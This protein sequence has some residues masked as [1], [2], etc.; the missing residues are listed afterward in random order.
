MHKISTFLIFLIVSFNLLDVY[1]VS[2]QQ[3]SASTGELEIG[4]GLKVELSCTSLVSSSVV[5]SIKPGETTTYRVNLHSNNWVISVYLPAPV[6]QWYSQE[7]GFTSS[8]PITITPGL[9]V[10][11]DVEPTT[12]LEVYGPATLDSTEINWNG[13]SSSRDIPLRIDSN[14]AENSL[15]RIKVAHSMKIRIGVNVGLAMFSYNVAS[16]DLTELELKPELNDYVEVK[17]A[18]GQF[19]GLFASMFQGPFVLILPVFILML[20]VSIGIYKGKKNADAIAKKAKK[21]TVKQNFK[22]ETNTPEKKPKFCIYC[23]E[24]LNEKAKFCG[25][26]GK[27]RD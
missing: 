5:E 14:A 6:N 24:K 2:Q 20:I 23:G 27:P 25:N 17:S 7:V 3:V 22:Q 21:P 16:F 15:V 18:L 9:S 8:G 13:G 12:H 4:G 10:N 19:F 26:C 1:G 11:F